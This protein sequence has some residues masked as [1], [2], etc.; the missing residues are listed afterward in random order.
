MT[1]ESFVKAYEGEL[2]EELEKYEDAKAKA[3]RKIAL[4]SRKLVNPARAFN[5]ELKE[6]SLRTKKIMGV[7][8]PPRRSNLPGRGGSPV[9]VPELVQKP[10]KKKSLWEKLTTEDEE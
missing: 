6:G 7:A 2:R 5:Q 3:E 10:E 4:I 8:V 9:P 1:D